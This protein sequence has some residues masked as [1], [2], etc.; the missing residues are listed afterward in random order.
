MCVCKYLGIPQFIFPHPRLDFG[1]KECCLPARQKY[2]CQ[3]AACR[4]ETEI[5][6]HQ[7]SREISNPTCACGSEMKRPYGAPRLVVYG[8]LMDLTKGNGKLTISLDG[9]SHVLKT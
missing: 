2:V 6:H 7:R 5:Q 1:L 9:L 3:S 8:D 4:S